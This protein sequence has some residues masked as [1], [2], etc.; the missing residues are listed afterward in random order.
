METIRNETLILDDTPPVT[1]IS[2]AVPFTLTATDEGCG[3]NV[4]MYKI[5]GGSW[6]VYTG[7]F[8]LTEGEHTI[9]CYSTDKLGNVEQERSLVVRPPIEVA[10]N[11]K[12]IVALVFAIILL[13]AGVWSSKRRPWKGGK[14]RMA[15]VKAFTIVSLPFIVAEAG[16][17]IISLATGMLTIPPLVGV[18]TGVDLAI[19][20]AGMVVA[21][22]RLRGK[23]LTPV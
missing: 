18:G 12:P 8:T 3:V 10:V 9:Y 23:N 13:V 5:D 17:G 7:G 20:M 11:Y 22:L 21:V 4:T 1:T 6:T 2:P 14:E 15:V 16:T 19:L